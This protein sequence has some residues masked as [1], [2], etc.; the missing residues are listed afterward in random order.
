M[1]TT[2]NAMLL[3]LGRWRIIGVLLAALVALA[4]A[5]CNALRL[6]Y[7]Q[8]PALAHWWIDNYLDITDEQEAPLKQ[9]LADYYRWHRAQQLPEYAALLQRAQAEATQP[10]TPQQVCGWMAEG[11]R[12]A[13][14]ALKHG[15]PMVVPLVRTVSAEQVRHLERKFAKSNREFRDDHLQSDPKERRKA[16]LKRVRERAEMMYGRLDDKQREWLEQAVAASPYDPER[17][18]AE[19]L[20]RQHD[21][22]QTL[23][24][25]LASPQM[26]PAQAEAMVGALGE[27]LLRSPRPEYRDYLTR[28][29]DYNCGL[30][31]HLHGMTTPQQREHARDKL[32]GWEMDA[33][34]LVIRTEP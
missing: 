28:L 11:R 32:R 14:I 2:F 19:R 5:G 16:A 15:V 34:S 17:W 31:A 9:A 10:V 6:T 22:V 29:Q 33:R 24:A 3:S 23:R 27:R 13:D 30:V 18:N 20:A 12:R 1:M 26:A 8:A 21:I 4:L 7:S 25:L